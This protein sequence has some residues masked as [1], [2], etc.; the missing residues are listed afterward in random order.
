MTLPLVIVV[1]VSENGI[2][3]K[4]NGLSWRLPSDMKRFRRITMG[5]PLVMGRKT[6]EGISRKLPGREIVV[7]TRDKSYAFEGVHVVHSLDEALAKAELLAAGMGADEIIVAGGGEVYAALL[8]Q[9][10][11]I[12]LTW[13]HADIEGDVRFPKLDPKIWRELSREEQARQPGDDHAY[14]LIS[15]VRAHVKG[16]E[17][18]LGAT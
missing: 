11:R 7:V 16:A 9:A 5:K 12:D 3:G 14:A 2:I 15:L 6:F 17:A 4:D 18:R 10:S 13:V 8:P 1:A